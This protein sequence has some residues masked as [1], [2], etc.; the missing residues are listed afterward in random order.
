LA[1]QLKE[2]GGKG[3]DGESKEREGEEMRGG[4]GREIEER[5]KQGD[6]EDRREEGREIGFY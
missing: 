3:R 2:R 1:K 5:E 4:R 6:R